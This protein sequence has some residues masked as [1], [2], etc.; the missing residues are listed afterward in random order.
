M[1]T[2]LQRKM[3][4]ESCVLSCGHKTT[5]TY[6]GHETSTTTAR[7]HFKASN[8]RPRRSALS[9]L[10]NRILLVLSET[11][12]NGDR[13]RS[14]KNR[15]GGGGGGGA[16]THKI[17]AQQETDTKLFLDGNQSNIIRIFV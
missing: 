13:H 4:N 12:V 11:Q 2:A 9:I 14:S 17:M 5:G 10:R 1:F 7:R 6:L 3:N 16:D 15:P 8:G